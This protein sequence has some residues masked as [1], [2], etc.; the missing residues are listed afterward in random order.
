[1][2][3]ALRIVGHPAVVLLFR[4]FV[5]GAFVLAAWPK[6]ADPQAFAMTISNYRILPDNLIHLTAI[7]LPWVEAVCGVA[8]ILGLWTRAAT[9][10][11]LGMLL[12]F[13][14]FII[15]A[16]A[17][18]L[19]ISCGCFDPSPRGK[20]MSSMTLI[21]D[22]I[23]MGM[24]VHILIFERPFLGLDALFNWRRHKKEKDS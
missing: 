24:G 5:G 10:A 7:L 3:L 8:L 9:V 22:I 20:H 21:W 18:N 4:L 23:W 6:I 11:I 13:V 16:I 17:R 12:I 15:S 1:M 2:S 14:I 19:D